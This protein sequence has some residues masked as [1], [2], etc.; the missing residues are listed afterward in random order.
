MLSGFSANRIN[1]VVP[2]R[3]WACVCVW[4]QVSKGQSFTHLLPLKEWNESEAKV[5]RQEQTKFWTRL[6]I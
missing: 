1:K 3:L 4:K 2:L 5:H 6:W